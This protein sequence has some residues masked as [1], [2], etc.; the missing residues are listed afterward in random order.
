MSRGGMVVETR[1]CSRLGKVFVV[2]AGDGDGDGD[3]FLGW[4]DWVIDY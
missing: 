2:G 1:G 3:G 4:S